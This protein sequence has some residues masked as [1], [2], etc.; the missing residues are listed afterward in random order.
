MK[1]SFKKRILT[2]EKEEI[3]KSLLSDSVISRIVSD[4]LKAGAE[5]IHLVCLVAYCY[6][7]GL[8]RGYTKGYKDGQ[9]AGI[10]FACDT[11]NKKLDENEKKK[12]TANDH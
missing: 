1:E 6:Q 9:S 12:K 10:K 5:Q 8:E 2:N 11:F 4:C 7:L 3:Y